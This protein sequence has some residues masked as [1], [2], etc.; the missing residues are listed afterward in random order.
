MDEK[1]TILVTGVGNYW[2]AQ[3][4]ARLL[5]SPGLA[6][7]DGQPALENA[8]VIGLD[9]KPPGIE[10][11][12]LDFI[13]ADVRNPLL[14]E[15]LKSE[16]VDFVCHLA[17]SDR[18]KSSE[19][20]FDIN[21]MSTMKLLGA[22]AEAGIRKVVLR[23]STAVY[24]ARPGNPAFLTET[25]LLHGKESQGE[26][27]NLAEIE[28]FC[29][30][31]HRQVPEIGLTIL[32]FA[33]IIGPTADTNMTRYLKQPYVPVLL[34]F[35]P[36]MQVIHERD[37]VDALVYAL[38]NEVPGVFNVA[39]EGSP[40][41]TKLIALAGK[42]TLPVLHWFAYWGNSLSNRQHALQSAWPIEPD[43]LRYTWVADLTRM[44]EE[45][46]FIPQYTAEEAL[47]EFA[48]QQRQGK[49]MS[50][51]TAKALDEERLRDILER[52]RRMREQRV[53]SSDES[54]EGIVP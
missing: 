14:S 43:Y 2:G 48:S 22:C 28:T 24:G 36:L 39:A 16:Q 8:H 40:P 20:A 11:N 32:R 23:S 44:R 12:G 38:V 25:H 41:L 15:V 31:Y 54:N 6:R 13:Q 52:R 27:R 10:I 17:Y 30:G 26:T 7:N 53:V 33:S 45:M 9:A 29:S 4:A 19:T 18:E 5:N 1:T 51:E 35:N 47:R 49:Y 50:E 21:V 34:G 37:V 3:V 42:S 46:R